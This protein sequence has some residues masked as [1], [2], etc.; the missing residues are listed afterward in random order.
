MKTGAMTG[1]L[2]SVGRANPVFYNEMNM[3]TAIM[4]THS[5]S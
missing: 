5:Y 3:D 1:G 2:W 4:A